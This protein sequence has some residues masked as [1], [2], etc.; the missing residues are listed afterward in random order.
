M[1][2][3]RYAGQDYPV[4]HGET[5][6]DCLLRHGISISHSCKAGA[7]QS[8]LVK[9]SGA[10]DEAAQR[11][12]KDTLRAQGYFLA[13]SA[14]PDADLTVSPAGSAVRTQARIASL[15]SLN[16]TVLR[17]RLRT[18]APL[19]YFAGQFVSLFREDGLARSYSLASLPHEDH[20]ELHVR[21]VPGGA[22]SE[23]LHQTA[24]LE[25]AVELQGP[26][27]NCFYA[28]GNPEEPLL[29]AGA[30]TG[31]APLYGIVRDALRQGHQAPLWLFHGALTPEGLYL[32]PELTAL[33]EAHENFHYVR[34]VVSDHESIDQAILSRFPKLS[35]WRGYLCGDPALVNL[36]RKKMFLAGMASKS[37]YADAFLPSAPA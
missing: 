8:C 23:W 20:L 12:L 19:D 28:P 16:A 3:I 32:V 5:V 29:L 9:G 6:L 14:R 21:K 31:L 37:I 24:Q 17:V 4:R 11:G 27:G 30:G 2:N 34:S 22:M 36:L 33:A 18:E 15:D 10:I 13:C 26:S 35:G 25:T 1:P 7:C